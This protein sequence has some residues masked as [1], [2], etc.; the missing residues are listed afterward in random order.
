MPAR[1]EFRA[2][3]I[4]VQNRTRDEVY[5]ENCSAQFDR[6]LEF[7]SAH[8][9][10]RDV[11]AEAFAGSITGRLTFP[12][13]IHLIRHCMRTLRWSEIASAAEQR[14][15]DG[16]NHFWDSELKKLLEEYRRD[17]TRRV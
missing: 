7:V 12:A 6:V 5:I 8:P 14:L 10:E 16:G 3:C 1:D 4:E 11:F 17:A 9:E 15:S 2:L 13:G